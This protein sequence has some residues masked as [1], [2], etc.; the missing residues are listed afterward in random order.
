MSNLYDLINQKNTLSQGNIY[1]KKIKG[2]EYFYHQYNENGKKITKIVKKDEL[3]KL[4]S[5]IEERK[6]IEQQ[7]KAILKS[8]NRDLSLSTNAKELTGY[9]MKQDK[10]VAEFNKGV[11][12]FEDT[13]YSPIIINRT[14]TLEPFLKYRSIDSG[15]TN[16]R[17][18]KKVLN[19]KTNDENIVSLCSYAASI[20]DDYWFKP[21]HSKLKYNDITFDNDMFFDTSL[22]GLITVYPNK[23]VL[24]P[25]LTTNGSYEK[26]W[27][28]INGEWWLYKV[29]SK[30]EIFSELFYSRL[31]EKLNLPT[32]HYEYDK[33]YILSKNFAETYNFEPLVAIVGD[34]FDIYEIAKSL[35]QYGHNI[36][37]DYLRLCAFDVILNNVDRHNENS[38]VLR[39]RRSGKIISL[40]PNFDDNLSL[41]SRTNTLPLSESDGFLSLFIKTLKRNKEL[42]NMYKEI[43]FPLIN[44]EVI[45]EVFNDIDI[46]VDRDNITKYILLRYNL[47]MNEINN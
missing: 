3:E 40:A 11:M 34:E 26:G 21:K 17:L 19:I 39:D 4:T 44:K 14:K 36:A 30:E 42:K 24:T 13:K 27:K 20:S 46:E 41:I 18:L 8:G 7:I 6:R 45:D 16:S 43:S 29:G 28:N 32:A 1:V 9:V 12:V 5:E 47:I 33:E 37:L 31:F 35:N 10:I 15:R 38:G 22:K 25:E 23:I 2:K